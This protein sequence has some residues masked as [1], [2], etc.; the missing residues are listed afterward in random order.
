MIYYTEKGTVE[1]YVIQELQK[2][3]WRY[4][5]PDD[6]NL[7]RKG[8]FEEP[9]V[10]ENLT[11]AL[12][13]INGDVELTEADLGFVITSLRTIPANI[14]G[15][16]RFLDIIRNGLVV[17]LQKEQKEKVIK[18]IDFKNLENNEFV[19]TNQFKVEGIKPDRPDI[20]LLINGIPLVLIEAKSPVREEVDWTTAYKQIKRYEEEIPEIFKYIQFSMAT[21]GVKTYYFPNAFREET[22]ERNFLGVWKDP[23]PYKKE[24][25]KDDILK[26]S[27]Y[28]LLSRHNLLDII[29]NFIFVRKEMDRKTKVM[30]RYMQFRATNKIFQ[31]VIQTL[32]KKK[33]EK[34]G[35]IWHWQGSGKTYTK[36]SRHGNSSTL[37]KLKNRAYSS[38]WIE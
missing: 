25:F 27:I 33:E 26:I 29:E 24:E 11:S 19:V 12:I 4:I 28:G 18:L 6:M 7:I 37:Q 17:P 38:W 31:R 3:G 22:E 23:Y 35:L 32:Q 13:R 34:F 36:H 9:L 2:L 5:K 20:V 14:E 30:A 15:I 21:D 10:I 1:N 16:E 8:N